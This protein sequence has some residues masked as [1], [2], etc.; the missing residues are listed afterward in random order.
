M[1]PPAGVYFTALL[2]RLMNTWFIFKASAMTSSFTTSK[3]SIKSSSC[4]AFTWGW[5]ILTRLCI[6]SEILHSCSLICTFPLSILLMSRISLIRLSKWLLEESTFCRLS[7]TCSLLSI[8]L[9]A[10]VVKPIMA[11]IGVRMSWDILERKVVFAR[12]ACCACIKASCRA[13]VCSRCFFSVS[14]I[15]F[16]TTITIIS[17]VSESFTIRKDWRTQTSVPVGSCSQYSM[18]TSP[19]PRANRSFK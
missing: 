14:V 2:K 18:A 19:S 3:V 11:F 10:M 6:I 17:S 5:M 8:W 9:A 7:F 15:S 13:W 4:F 12:L 1:L 16:V